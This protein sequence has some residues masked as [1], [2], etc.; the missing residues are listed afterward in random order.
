MR[1]SFKVFII[2]LLLC[3]IAISCTTPAVDNSSGSKDT[4]VV[5]VDTVPAK[6]TVPQ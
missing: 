1:N 5:T 3:M 6:T 2:L 4:I